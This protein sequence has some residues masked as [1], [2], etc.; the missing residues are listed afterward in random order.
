MPMA[1]HDI[2]GA[3][4][5]SPRTAMV[6]LDCQREK[7]YQLLNNGEL[8]SYLEG[9]SRKIIVASIHRLI[10]RRLAAARDARAHKPGR[11]EM[12]NSTTAA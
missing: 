12:P 4:V 3:L 11:A 2:D 10:D 9:T 8:E 6:M 1:Q 5:C 7:L